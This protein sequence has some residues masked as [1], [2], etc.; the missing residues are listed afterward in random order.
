[1]NNITAL[2]QKKERQNLIVKQICAVAKAINCTFTLKN[3]PI[4][5]EKAFDTNGLLP[6]IARRAD[7][8][9]S[10]CM[11][12][13]IGVTFERVEEAILG[14]GVNFDEKVPI[15]LRLLC[16][17]DVILEMVYSGDSNQ[18]VALDSLMDD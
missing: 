11:G 6:A 4:E 15:S 9:C 13:G 10:F 14:V 3:E 16:I 7:Q 5:I 12:Y 2:K 8:L 17:T 18:I 1:M